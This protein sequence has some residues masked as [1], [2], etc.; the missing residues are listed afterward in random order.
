MAEGKFADLPGKGKPLDLDD[1]PH[2]DPEWR[3]AYHILRNAGFSLP[4]IEALREI[5][6]DLQSA[7]A[8]LTRAWNWQLST[9]AQDSH[10]ELATAE[11]E[12]ARQ[13]FR[14]QVSELNRRIR[15]AN[16]A[17]PNSRFQRRP[18]DPDQEIQA[19]T[20]VNSNP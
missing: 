8:S 12:H 11:W 3:L 20:Q 10:S 2:E 13:D 14:R 4:W 16:L 9:R 17:V 1:N 15:T 7:R 5:E 6:V 19:L 18:I